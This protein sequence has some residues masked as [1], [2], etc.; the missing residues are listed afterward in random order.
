MKILRMLFAFQFIVW[1][2]AKLKGPLFSLGA[3]QQLGKAL[4]Y[5]GWKG[6]DV[7]REYVIPANPKTAL[8]VTQR[9]YLTQAVLT[10]HTSQAWAAHP[11]NAADIAAYALWASVVKPATTWFNQAVKILV[12]QLVASKHPLH[13][14][15]G[16][17][18]PSA[19]Q[20]ILK[21]TQNA[22]YATTV[23]CYYGTSKTALINSKLCTLAA[24]TFTA[25]LTGLTKGV[26]YYMQ[27]RPTVPVSSIGGD[28]GI[29]YGYPT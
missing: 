5:F 16:S 10:I 2:G 19:A 24:Q 21:I 1:F 26:K 17:V 8:Q 28:S 11:T 9:G 20:L 18:T 7:V 27:F 25:T 23:Y 3:T 13:W 4:V 14:S 12:D 29:Y 6:L 15:D 22:A